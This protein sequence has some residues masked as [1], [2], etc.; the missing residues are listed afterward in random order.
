MVFCCRD[1]IFGGERPCSALKKDFPD[2][3]KEAAKRFLVK[4]VNNNGIPEKIIIDGSAANKAA[5]EEL[6]SDNDT[7]IEV[8]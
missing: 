2:E 1:V 7:T 6:N 5:I 3:P 8:R 4:A